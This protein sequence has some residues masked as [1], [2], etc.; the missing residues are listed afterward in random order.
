MTARVNSDVCENLFSQV[1]GIGGSQV[2]PGPVTVMNRLRS[3]QLVR[4]ANS[5]VKDPVVAQDD[6]EHEQFLLQHPVGGGQIVNLPEI[7]EVNNLIQTDF[8]IK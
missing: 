8:V 1:R 7:S 6:D 2:H 3:L 5:L 4:N